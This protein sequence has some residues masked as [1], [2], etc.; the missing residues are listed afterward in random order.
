MTDPPRIT[1]VTPSFN[2]ASYLEETLNSVLSQNDPN[3]EYIVIDGGSTD[4]SVDIIR[5]YADRLAYWVSE[6]DGGQ[7]AA[8]NKGFAR[9]TGEVFGF[10]NSDD[11]FCSGA[12]AA[13]AEAYRRT[14]RREAFWQAFAV[15]NFDHEGT[16]FVVRPRPYARL[17]DWIDG[18]ASL[19]QPGVFWS[20]ELHQSLGG[21][22][23]SYQYAFDRKFFA[24]A[25]RRGFRVRV[26]RDFV[27]TRFRLHENSKTVRYGGLTAERE[28]GV[29]FSRLAGELTADAGPVD[30]CRLAWERTVRFLEARGRVLLEDL[31]ESRFRRL[32]QLAL[33]GLIYPPNAGTRFFWGA[34]RRTLLTVPPVKGQ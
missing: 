6:P 23:E 1:I 8:L 25:V 28:F 3:L 18:V 5:R 29:E 2:Q 20:R 30:R 17:A 31:P 27:S 12:L 22:D 7:A 11:V 24:T 34:V 33:A 10:L 19:H 4:G 13:V 26:N 32:G 9:A 16:T 15:E 14:E 21:F